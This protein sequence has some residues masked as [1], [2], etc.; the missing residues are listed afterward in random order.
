MKSTR[1]LLLAT[2]IALL[3]GCSAKPYI[4]PTGADVGTLLLV[5][6]T[7]SGGYR[8]LIDGRDAGLLVDRRTIPVTPGR[9]SIRLS[10][11]E[12]VVRSEMREVDHRYSTTVSVARGEVK[13]VTLSPK[14]AG[15]TLKEGKWKPLP[16]HEEQPS[17]MEQKLRQE[18]ADFGD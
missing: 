7:E 13:E 5:N 6:A 12:T 4:L 11:K 18:G 16:G 10:K 14:S 9:H 3:A 17:L 1:L 15:Y 2:L 8:I